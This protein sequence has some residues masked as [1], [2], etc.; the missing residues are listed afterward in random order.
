MQSAL[1]CAFAWAYIF[2]PGPRLLDRE[3]TS[4]AGLLLS[5]VGL[6]LLVSAI[7]SLRRVIQIEPEPRAGGHL[8][9]RGV[10]RHLRHPI[11]TAIVILVIGLFLRK[12]AAAVAVAAAAVI[13]F[14]AVKVRI[15]ERLLVARY[16]EYSHYKARTWGLILWPPRTRHRK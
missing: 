16:P 4:T 11:Y 6:A 1:L 14:L 15:E 7:M 2:N 10:Y 5:A 9:T 8:V 3:I 12:P 13:V